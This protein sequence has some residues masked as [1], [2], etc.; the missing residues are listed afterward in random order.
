[1]TPAER[2][3]RPNADRSRHRRDRAAHAR[4]RCPRR[5]PRASATSCWW[6]RRSPTR[7]L[8][9]ASGFAIRCSSAAFIR[10]CP[11]NRQSVEPVGHAARADHA[12]TA[13]RSSPSG[14]ST[15]VSLEQLV[16]H[17]VIHEVGHH[18]GFSDDDMHALEDER[19]VSAAAAVR[20]G[21]AAARRASCCSR[22]STSRSAPARRCRSPARMAAASRA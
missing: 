12:S 5:S 15:G 3:V 14:A 8:R 10:A 6:S 22:A 9:A 21:R 17:I 4:A 7:R 11:L 13:G 2:L 1:M 20:T 18:F 16:A 19:G